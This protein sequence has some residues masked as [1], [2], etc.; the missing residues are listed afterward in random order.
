MDRDTGSFTAGKKTRNN[1]V[2]AIFVDCE[3]LTRV[4][5]RNAAHVVMNRR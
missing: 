4:F 3:D 5:G 1:L 2:I